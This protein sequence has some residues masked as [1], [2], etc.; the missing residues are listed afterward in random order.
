MF[1]IVL[2]S[3]KIPQ[4]TGTIGRTCVAIGA[5]LHIVRP[6]PFDLSEKAVRRAGL[7]YWPDLELYVWDDFQAFRSAHPATDRHFFATTKCDRPYF[8]VSYQ[9]GDFLYF[10]SEDSGLPS[11]LLFS[12]QES[13][14]TIPMREGY[15]SLNLSNAVSIIAYEGL[16]QNF[17]SFDPSL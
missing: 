17:R 4:N 16:R 8:D 11:E 13:L 12:H 3:P 15:R 6:I 2:V 5:A 7:D 1:N 14:V 9:K 10:G